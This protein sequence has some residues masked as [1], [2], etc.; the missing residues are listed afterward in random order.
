MLLM[1]R[2]GQ[3]QRVSGQ[4][5]DPNIEHIHCVPCAEPGRPLRV[6][7]LLAN[8]GYG[9]RKECQGLVKQGRVLRKGER[10]KVCVDLPLCAQVFYTC[11]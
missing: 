5:N 8:L 10:L 1:Q 6:E 2:Q 11:T 3:R 7:R 9:K 4:R